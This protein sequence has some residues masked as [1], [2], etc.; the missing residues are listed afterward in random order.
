MNNDQILNH[1]LTTKT[2]N[3]LTPDQETTF[4]QIIFNTTDTDFDDSDISH[5][6]DYFLDNT[7]EFTLN[8]NK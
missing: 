1:V 5:A 3:N 6:I 4:C 2:T 7:S 8:Q